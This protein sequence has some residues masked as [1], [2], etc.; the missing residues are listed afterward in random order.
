MGLCRAVDVGAA[1]LHPPDQI[2][3]ETD[4]RI[5]AAYGTAFDGLQQEAHRLSAADLKR[6]TTGGAVPAS[7]VD[8]AFRTAKDTP[9]AT[10]GARP[11][12]M[13]V[14]AVTA[15]NDPKFDAAA[16]ETKQMADGLKPALTESLLAEYVAQLQ[17]DYGVSINP[18]VFNQIVGGGTAAN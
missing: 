4:D 18:T 17:V 7:V 15:V 6:N 16:A 11:T 13:I 12:G 2:W 5:A 3:L 9:V 1:V 14:F 8:L 10:E